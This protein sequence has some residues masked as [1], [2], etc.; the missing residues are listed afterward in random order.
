MES[1]SAVTGPMITGPRGAVRLP[2]IDLVGIDQHGGLDD[3]RDDQA[4][5]GD[6]RRASIVGRARAGIDEAAIDAAADDHGAA[7][8]R[9]VA[10]AVGKVWCRSGRWCRH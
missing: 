10:A 6:H 5:G 2:V 9:I 7:G 8:F 4:R 1:I 3:A